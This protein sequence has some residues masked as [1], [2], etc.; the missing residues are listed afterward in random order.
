MRGAIFSVTVRATIITSDCR[1]EGR[2]TPAP[3][4]SMSNRDAPVAI[5]SMAQQ[6][7]PNV[8]GQ[9]LDL[10]AQLK[11]Q[12]SEVVTTLGSILPSRKPTKALLPAQDRP[13]APR[14]PTAPPVGRTGGNTRVKP[15]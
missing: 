10:R 13:L 5:I 2:K 4:R 3:N 15:W 7:R 9:G 12:S 8:I 6:A 14:P 11:S 1:G